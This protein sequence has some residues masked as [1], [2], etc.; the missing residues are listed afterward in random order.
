MNNDIAEE[1]RSSAGISCEMSCKGAARM[2]KFRE[3][4]AK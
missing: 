3:A 1:L 2:A 4:R